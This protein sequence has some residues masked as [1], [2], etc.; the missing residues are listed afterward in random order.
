MDASAGKSRTRCKEGVGGLSW[1]QRSQLNVEMTGTQHVAVGQQ[2]EVQVTT[3]GT[4]VDS[5][6]AWE[7]WC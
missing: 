2:R 5:D 7:S 6:V 3:I 4:K 1:R